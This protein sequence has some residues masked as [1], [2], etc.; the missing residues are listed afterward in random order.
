MFSSPNSSRFNTSTS[1]YACAAVR[2]LF[3]YSAHPPDR[4][5][6]RSAHPPDRSKRRIHAQIDRAPQI[7]R[8]LTRQHGLNKAYQA[9]IKCT[10]SP[11]QIQINES[12]NKRMICTICMIYLVYP[13][14]LSS[15]SSACVLV[16]LPVFTCVISCSCAPSYRPGYGA[17]YMAV[18][19]LVTSSSRV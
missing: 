18:Y 11:I 15:F 1:T 10:Y 7:V 13:L 5:S 4:S 14:S 2:R 19:R 17:I 6:R 9:Q 3:L 12:M 8:H 16:V